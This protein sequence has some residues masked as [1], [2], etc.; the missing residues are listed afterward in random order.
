MK[1][2]RKDINDLEKEVIA[3]YRAYGFIQADCGHILRE[4]DKMI[5]VRTN[6]T[7]EYYILCE[8]CDA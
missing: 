7:K 1:V 3:T 6:D 2:N 5:V 4:G 8:V